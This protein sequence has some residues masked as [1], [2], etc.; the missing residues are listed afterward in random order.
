MEE[1]D[2]IRRAAAQSVGRGCGFALLAIGMTMFGLISWPILAFRS[3]A[4]L[5]ALMAAVLE[6]RRTL[7]RR[8]DYRRTETWLLMGQQTDMPAARAQPVIVGILAETYWRFAAYAAALSL[9]CWLLM[10]LTMA[11]Q[12]PDAPW[13]FTKTE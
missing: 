10:A 6:L 4:I 7:A 2:R 12:P 8:Q 1:I 9:L 11:I 13:V 5:M 3:G